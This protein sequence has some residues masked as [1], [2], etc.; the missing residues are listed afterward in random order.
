[1]EDAAAFGWSYWV[2]ALFSEISSL[3]GEEIA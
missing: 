2:S 3:I 1:M